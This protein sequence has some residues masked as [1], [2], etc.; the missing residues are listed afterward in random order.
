MLDYTFHLLF[1]PGTSFHAVHFHWRR[2]KP[3][4]LLCYVEG[5]VL[6]EGR[7]HQILDLAGEMQIKIEI[8]K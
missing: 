3:P 6:F 8:L 7:K 2:R 1:P 5:S 4:R